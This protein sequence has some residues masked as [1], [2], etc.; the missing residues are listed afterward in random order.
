MLG[1]LLGSVVSVF[2]K[3]K[4]NTLF[5]A[6]QNKRL[7]ILGGVI[8]AALLGIASPLCMYCPLPVSV[9]PDIRLIKLCAICLC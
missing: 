5:A 9:L 7:G 2:G 4:I 1:I 6:L 8:P 3:A